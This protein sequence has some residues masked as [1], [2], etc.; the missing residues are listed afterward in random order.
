MLENQGQ[1]T[2]LP[3]QQEIKPL[4]PAAQ[5][6][7]DQRLAA[8]QGEQVTP[9]APATQEEQEVPLEIQQALLEIARRYEQQC[10]SLTRGLRKQM[11]EGEEFW[12]SNHY[13]I[14]DEGAHKYWNPTSFADANPGVEAPRYDYVT[15]LYKTWG[16]IAI[17]AV[18][19]KIPKVRAK[20]SSAKSEKDIATAKAF[21]RIA[22]LI[23]RNNKMGS[24]VRDEGR[25]LYVQG[26]FGAYCRF[27]RS[28]EY[29]VREEPQIEMQQ[30]PLREEGLDCPT[31]GYSMPMPEQNALVPTPIEMSCPECGQMLT[32]ENYIPAE[33]GEAPV[34]TGTKKVAAG[35]EKI[36]IKGLLHLKLLPYANNQ[37]ESPYLIDSSLAPTAAVRAAWPAVAEKIGDGVEGQDDSRDSRDQASLFGA[38][39]S[40]GSRSSNPKG[41]VL[42]KQCWIRPW[43]FW[44]HPAKEMVN[45]LLKLYPDGVHFDYC[46]KVFL[47]AKNEN[48]DKFW[49]LCIGPL[50]NGIYRGG[51]G[52]DAISINKRY[53]DV[54]NIQQEYVEHAA[55]P[56]VI[57]DGRFIS[58]EA[59]QSK[60]QEA[61]G[62]LLVHP[63]NAGQQVTLSSM[64]H[65]PTQR[66]DGNIYQYGSSLVDLG[67]MVTGSLPSV[68]GGGVQFNETLGGYSQA[69]EDALGRLQLIWKSVREFHA[70]LMLIAVECFRE[71]RTEDTELTV[72]QKSGEFASEYVRLD[73]IQGNIT[74]EPEVD[75][76]FP[77]TTSE[78]RENIA[79]LL[80]YAPEWVMPLLTSPSNVDF[81]KRVLGSPDL[82]IPAEAARE[83]T[84]RMID[85]LIQAPPA[86]MDPMTGKVVPSIQ[87]EMFVDDHI[88]AI[89]TIKEWSQSSDPNQ[90]IQV[91]Q[92]NP[93][94]YENVIAFM[95][96]HIEQAENE[97]ALMAPPP[98]EGEGNKSSKP[99]DNG[100]PP[101]KENK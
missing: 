66:L 12:K 69:R 2:S 60:R 7:T 62:L 14:W 67:Q 34:V 20:P 44:E 98:V 65:Q 96:T 51:T 26:G 87:P 31:C 16:T 5:T 91:K 64:L 63:E 52:H 22:S 8:G 94:G 10:D 81:A 27:V 101:N 82:I 40:Y 29:G 53:N 18:T 39:R 86:G 85:L 99:K 50:G 45:K 71:N 70:E 43:G 37:K 23:E 49:R 58:A 56:T 41:M 59:W 61:G 73:E 25:L 97:M 1:E 93:L 46:G 79:K 88:T 19:R 84:F 92:E 3:S 89:T 9:D 78:L 30:V 80:Q 28:E 54:A 57:G 42:L 75:E 48:V 21:D 77:A 100:K 15:N 55:F 83:K 36:D 33:F 35:I 24:L 74:I 76:D 13:P 11:L 4:S 90:G 72:I 17:A 95:L 38:P 68:F 47:G 6:Y 32:E